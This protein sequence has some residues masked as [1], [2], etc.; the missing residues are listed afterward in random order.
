[1]LDALAL[2][3]VFQLLG[4][5]VSYGLKLPIPGPVIGMAALFWAWPYLGRAQQELDRVATTLLSHLSLLFV[6]A[7]VGVMLHVGLIAA[8]W[9]P[10]LL[11]IVLSSLT[12]M[13][14]VV[15]LFV[16]MRKGHAA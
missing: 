16:R 5:T 11:A 6:P 7:G 13:L 14:V 10:L 9:A 3:L 1:M 8:W 12:T 4:E 15:G 2:L